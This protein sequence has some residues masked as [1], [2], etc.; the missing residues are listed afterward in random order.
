MKR[1]SK[2]WIVILGYQ[3]QILPPI[4]VRI[5]TMQTTSTLQFQINIRFQVF[6]LYSKFLVSLVACTNCIKF[7]KKWIIQML[8]ILDC[9]CQEGS[10]P[11]C[12]PQLVFWMHFCY[13]CQHAISTQCRRFIIYLHTDA[14]H[15]KIW[16]IRKKTTIQISIKD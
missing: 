16:D 2:L 10:N 9:P 5:Q 6:K 12:I 8:T 14:Q 13:H 15:I 4:I 11:T 3:S 1:N 7:V